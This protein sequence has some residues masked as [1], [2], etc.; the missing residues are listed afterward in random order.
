MGRKTILG[1]VA[2]NLNLIFR[3]QY[4]PIEFKVNTDHWPVEYLQD[5]NNIRLPELFIYV[6]NAIAEKTSTPTP[7]IQIAKT[8][9]DMES[10]TISIE[11]S[12]SGRCVHWAIVYAKKGN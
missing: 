12:I 3:G 1:R 6:T 11:G 2:V 5:L 4:T 9:V 10:E 7:I 8:E